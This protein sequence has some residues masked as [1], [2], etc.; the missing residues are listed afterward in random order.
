[1]A[2][3]S[4]QW[5]II[6]ALRQLHAALGTTFTRR[7]YQ[8]VIKPI[9]VA[10]GRNDMNTGGWISTNQTRPFHLIPS[11]RDSAD[12]V[13]KITQIWSDLAGLDLSIEIA[14]EEHSLDEWSIHENLEPYDSWMDRRMASLP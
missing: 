6:Q 13:F 4:D 10:Y 8:Y 12:D 1:M 11:G 9:L 5:L 3:E 2:K 7:E 14:D